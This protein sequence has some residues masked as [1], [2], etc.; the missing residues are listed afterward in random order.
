MLTK[1]GA[2]FFVFIVAS[3]AFCSFICN[4]A[5]GNNPSISNEKSTK[6]FAIR[7]IGLVAT[8][9]EIKQDAFTAI[10]AINANAITIM[11]YAFCSVDQPTVMYNNARQWWGE[12]D[13]V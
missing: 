10:N 6:N 3:I 2:V 8:V 11:P 9:N 4:N 7:G 5:V 12:K 1:L 13:D